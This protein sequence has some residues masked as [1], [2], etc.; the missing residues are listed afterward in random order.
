MKHNHNAQAIGSLKTEFSILRSEIDTLMDSKN[1]AIE[2]SN[3]F[4]ADL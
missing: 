2:A 4:I 3:T 1:R